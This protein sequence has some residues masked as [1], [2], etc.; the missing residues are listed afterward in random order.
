MQFNT[1]QLIG[2]HDVLFMTLDTLRYDV[3]AEC[4]ATGLTPNLA[5]H[6]P[7]NRWEER[8]SPGSF[9]YSAHH[10][11]FAGF[12]PTPITPGP[13]PRLFAADFAGSETTTT[14]TF[15]YDAPTF[16]E[17][18]HN[19]GYHTACI[20]GVGFFNGKTPMGRVLPGL[21]AESHW[22]A[23]MG[24]TCP[25]ST[26]RQVETACRMLA[27]LPSTRR[28]FLFINISAI[29]QPNRIFM[30]GAET[31]SCKT[32]AAA[33]AY[34]DTCLPPLLAALQTR[35]NTLCIICSDHGTA[36]GEDGYVGHRLSH[37]VVWTVPYA[38]FVLTQLERPAP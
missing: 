29:H 23:D 20:G 2:S 27:T 22:S 7:D 1:R 10:A 16:V 38:E 36:Y 17:G 24:V 26:E 12:L 37:P 34:V 13:H 8:H 18:L 19:V 21:F 25:F 28:V 14:H 33:L 5:R 30:S 11:F 3:A 9:T 4:L 32:Q 15:V 31:D 35:S 6:L